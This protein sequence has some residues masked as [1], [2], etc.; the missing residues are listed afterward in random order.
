MQRVEV[1]DYRNYKIDKL[2]KVSCSFVDSFVW[3]LVPLWIRSTRKILLTPDRRV[4]ATVWDIIDDGQT[5]SCDCIKYYWRRTDVFPRLHEILLTTDRHVPATV[6]KILLMTDR[7][8]PATSWLLSRTWHYIP[9][10][11]VNARCITS[12][13]VF[14]FDSFFPIVCA[15]EFLFKCIHL[16]F[17]ISYRY[18]C[19]LFRICLIVF[20]PFRCF[21]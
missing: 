4:P 2:T 17:I 14:Q 5:F 18:T 19:L 21:D 16:H 8:V 9:H 15:P 1:R 10:Y 13:S 3:S 7:H 11:S 6:R 12:N 20:F